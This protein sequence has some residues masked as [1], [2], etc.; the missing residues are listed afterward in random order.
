M[1]TSSP[2]PNAE[3][4]YCAVFADGTKLIKARHVVGR[5]RVRTITIPSSVQ[6]IE[7]GAFEGALNAPVPSN[8]CPVPG[9]RCPACCAHDLSLPSVILPSARPIHM[10]RSP[11]ARLPMRRLFEARENHLSKPQRQP[12]AAGDLQACVCRLRRPARNCT[13]APSHGHW[14]QRVQGLQVAA[15]GHADQPD[16]SPQPQLV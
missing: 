1:G 2:V 12:E 11:P 14:R 13:R 15:F 5:K 4:S 6:K 9:A 16:A 10:S 7:A 8:V 3:N